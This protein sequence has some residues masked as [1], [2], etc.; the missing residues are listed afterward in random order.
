MSKEIIEFEYS[1]DILFNP[2]KINVGNEDELN[3]RLLKTGAYSLLCKRSFVY[4]FKGIS[5]L[6]DLDDGR[7][8][9]SRY[10]SA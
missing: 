4:H 10:H 7:N 5:F 6:G 8:D 3:D 9:L 1:K 2:D